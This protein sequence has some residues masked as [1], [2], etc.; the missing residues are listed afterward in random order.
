MAKSKLEK[1][2]SIEEEIEQ[3]TARK[4]LLLAQQKEDERKARNHRLCKRGGMWESLLPETITLTDEQFR[5]FLEK[6]IVTEF[7]RRILGEL[8]RQSPTPTAEPKSEPGAVQSGT[9]GAGSEG[10]GT[11]ES[12]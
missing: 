12:S 11:R 2:T 3:L 7:A 4:K 10:N 1:I 9:A 6:T 8:Q 5:T